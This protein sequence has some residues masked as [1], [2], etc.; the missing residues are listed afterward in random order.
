VLAF[1]TDYFQNIGGEA[2][3]REFLK[4]RAVSTVFLLHE[5]RDPEYEIELGVF[6]P[7]YG[8]GGEQYSTSKETDWVVYAAHESSITMAS[9]PLS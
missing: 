1:H 2:L 8:D 3:L 4:K 6:V 9:K 7:G 5:F